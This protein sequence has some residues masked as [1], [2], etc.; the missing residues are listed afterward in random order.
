MDRR[1]RGRWRCSC[2]AS[3]SCCS[4][5]WARCR[6]CSY[7]CAAVTTTPAF[8]PLGVPRQSDLPVLLAASWWLV[9]V[10]ALGNVAYSGFILGML[11]L[12]P[13][14]VTVAILRHDL[15]DID[16]LISSSTAWALTTIVSASI[17]AATVAVSAELFG[18]HFRFGTTG[19][20]FVTGLLLL[21][22]HQRVHRLTGRLFDRERTVMLATMERFVDDVRRGRQEPERVEDVLCGCGRRTTP[23]ARA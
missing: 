17:F 4:R 23:S 5:C 3:G 9:A 1:R 20:A 22:V 16:R 18:D 13:A 21:P 15:F 6:A 10:G 8:S 7:G 2:P 14:A 12:V 19:A 11:V